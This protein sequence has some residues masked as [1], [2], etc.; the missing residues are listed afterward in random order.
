MWRLLVFLL[1]LAPVSAPAAAIAAPP[2]APASGSGAKAAKTPA[3]APEP[4]G[5]TTTNNN[6]PGGKKVISLDDEFLV[7]GQLEKPSAFYVLRRSSTDYDWARLDATMTP[8]VLESV[9][10]PLF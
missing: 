6:N 7:E 8:L 2:P 4:A 5:R 3:K 1:V 9:W 10:D